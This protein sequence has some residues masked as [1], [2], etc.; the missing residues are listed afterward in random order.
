MNRPTDIKIYTEPRVVSQM[1]A[2]IKATPNV[3]GKSHAQ[4]KVN[5]NPNFKRN[6]I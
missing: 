2:F 6:R 1:K 3:S 5:L 4:F